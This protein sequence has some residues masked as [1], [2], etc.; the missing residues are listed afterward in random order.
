MAE[1]AGLAHVSGGAAGWPRRDCGHG[2]VDKAISAETTLGTNDGFGYFDY[3]DNGNYPVTDGT[4][5]GA[6]N[7][8]IAHGLPAVLNDQSIT[9]D[10]IHSAPGALWAWGWYSGPVDWDGYEFVNGAVGAQ[11]TSYTANNIRYLGPGTWFPSGLAGITATW[12]A[13]GEPYTSGYANGDNL[14]NHFWNGYNFGESAY[15]A[16]PGTELGDGFCRGPVIPAEC[17][18]IGAAYPGADAQADLQCTTGRIYLF[19]TAYA[20]G[21]GIPKRGRRPVSGGRAEYRFGADAT[22]LPGHVPND[23]G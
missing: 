4:M 21:R 19:R 8:A 11:L 22:S 18:S 14:L 1:S 9:G 13:T 7:L 12:G 5:V 23:L 16:S 17:F 20:I 6:Y 3:Q 15:L 10:M 2:L